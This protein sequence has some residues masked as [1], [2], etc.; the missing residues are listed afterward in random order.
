MKKWCAILYLLVI[1][2]VMLLGVLADWS[3]SDQSDDG[4]LYYSVSFTS[5]WLL[6]SRFS[7]CSLIGPALANRIIEC[8]AIL[9]LLVVDDIMLL[10]VLAYWSSSDQSDDQILCYS[11]PPRGC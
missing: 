9:Y 8:C 4:I 7:G 6:T 3:S 2:N 5:S 1:A 11:L 10:G